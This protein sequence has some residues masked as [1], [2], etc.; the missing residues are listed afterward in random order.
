VEEKSLKEN[1]FYF[2]SYLL[3]RES[4]NLKVNIEN[5]PMEEWAA[6]LHSCKKNE[7]RDLYH[8]CFQQ[9]DSISLQYLML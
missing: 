9:N 2:L 6:C 1:Q 3:S 5:I 7:S 4:L 8:H